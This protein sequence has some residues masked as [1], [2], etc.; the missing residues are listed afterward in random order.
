MHMQL[1]EPE[2]NLPDNYSYELGRHTQ[3][4][5]DSKGTQ[6]VKVCINNQKMKKLRK[7]L[8]R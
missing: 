6:T 1:S 4:S 5:N 3:K 8:R 7:I 2:P